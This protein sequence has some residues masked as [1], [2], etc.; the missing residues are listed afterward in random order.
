MQLSQRI[1]G[2]FLDKVYLR[3]IL[4]E[5]EARPICPGLRGLHGDIYLTV[6]YIKVFTETEALGG[7]LRKEDKI[8]R[9]RNPNSNEE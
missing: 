2:W 4:L 9:L 1:P 7:Y 5:D 6:N 8:K 3:C